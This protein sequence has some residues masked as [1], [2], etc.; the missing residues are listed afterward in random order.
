[1]RNRRE[2]IFDRREKLRALGRATY[3]E[4]NKCALAPYNC[5]AAPNLTVSTN[6]NE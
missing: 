3:G 5:A 6:N 4:P 1:M 2:F